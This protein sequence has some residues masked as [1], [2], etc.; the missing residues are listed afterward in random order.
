VRSRSTPIPV[1]GAPSRPS[2]RRI[3]KDAGSN[4]FGTDGL[5]PEMRGRGPLL[6]IWKS[7]DCRSTVLKHLNPSFLSRKTVTNEGGGSK[8]AEPLQDPLPGRVT[9]SWIAVHCGGSSSLESLIATSLPPPT[10]NTLI[11]FRTN[12]QSVPREKVEARND[13]VCVT[14][15]TNRPCLLGD[16]PSVPSSSGLPESE[17]AL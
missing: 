9:Y 7:G 12:F 6:M 3:R 5:S 17:C 4:S 16:K 8:L 1:T 14:H 11:A 2:P 15:A 13:S 10:P